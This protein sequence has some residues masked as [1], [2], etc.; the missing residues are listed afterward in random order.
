MFQ[1]FYKDHLKLLKDELE[2]VINYPIITNKKFFIK[3]FFKNIIKYL[4]NI[5]APIICWRLYLDKSDNLINGAN[6]YERFKSFSNLRK[7][8]LLVLYPE[9]NNLIRN[10]LKE[11]VIFLSNFIEKIYKNWLGIKKFFNINSKLLYIVYPPSNDRHSFGK[12]TLFLKF[13]NKKYLKIKPHI[14]SYQP[15]FNSILEKF[16]KDTGGDLKM[17]KSIK[18]EDLWV[19]EFISL[20]NKNINKK[21]AEI[22]YENIG[23]LFGLTFFLNG[24]D[25]HMENIIAY[26]S[27]PILLDTE[28]IFT[29]Y[30]V[31]KNKNLMN[32]LLSTGFIERKT[33]E[34]PTSAIFGG[35]KK[36]ISLTQPIILYKFTDK[37][38]L[39]FKTF[40]KMPPHNRIYKDNKTLWNP[41]KFK[42]Q[43][44][45]GFEESYMWVLKNKDYILNLIDNQKEQIFSRIIL[46]K[47]SFYAILI[48]HVLQPINFPLKRFE[49]K[50]IKTLKENSKRFHKNYNEPY[51]EKIIKYEIENIKKLSVPIFWQNI[52]E[53]H[54]YL[55]EGVYKNFFPKTAFELLIEKF[56]KLT[57]KKLNYYL[58]KI[59]NYLS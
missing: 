42:K 2:K 40:S 43:I 16:N 4:D 19:S 21:T 8:N 18:I 46:R 48:Q 51:F 37:M 30:S 6:S 35:N 9:I 34:R 5:I 45:K 52:K 24:S 12:K 50:L 3:I 15:I 54:L 25:F 31:Y 44:I 56:Q 7:N 28:T 41:K 39:K 20:K 59:D 1:I 36:L 17:P 47:T 14:F 58:Q 38:R 49:L 22:F 55:D 29:N 26:K 10:Y 27:H 13:A 53:R 57:I 11:E 33:I 23:N 32:S